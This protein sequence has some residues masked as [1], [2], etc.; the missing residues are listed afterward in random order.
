LAC[1]NEARPKGPG[2]KRFYKAY[3]DENF[4]ARGKRERKENINKRTK[5]KKMIKTLL[6]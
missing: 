6:V 3:I 2:P 1:S 5:A 4:E